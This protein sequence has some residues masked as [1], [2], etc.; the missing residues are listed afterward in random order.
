MSDIVF[1][2]SPAEFAAVRRMMADH[3]AIMLA[4]DGDLKAV[5]DDLLG[6]AQRM[7]DAFWFSNTPKPFAD[8]ADNVIAFRSK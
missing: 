4:R 6:A 1:K 3:I 2:L 7:S 8:I 5:S